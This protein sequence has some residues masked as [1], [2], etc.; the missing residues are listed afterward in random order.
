MSGLLLALAGSLLR[1]SAGSRRVVNPFTHRCCL[2]LVDVGPGG[3][4]NRGEI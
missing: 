1:L 3:M 4:I 2:V